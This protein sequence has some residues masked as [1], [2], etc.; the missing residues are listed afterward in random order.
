M[1]SRITEYLD[2]RDPAQPFFLYAFFESPHARSDF[3]PETANP[4]MLV[5]TEDTLCTN[6]HLSAPTGLP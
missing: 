4:S 2:R 3:P 1:V 6:C 5:E